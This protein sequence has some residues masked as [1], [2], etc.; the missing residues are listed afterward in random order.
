MNR[1]VA[2]LALVFG[3]AGAISIGCGSDDDAASP[4]AGGAGGTAGSGGRAGAA[5]HAGSSG[6]AGARNDGGSAGEDGVAGSGAGAEQGGAGGD[7]GDAAG[8]GPGGEGGESGAGGAGHVFTQQ[9]LDR[10]KLI[11][12][13]MALGGGCHSVGATST[14]PAGPELGGNPAFFSSLGA[15][16]LT[17][18]PSG[19]G[20]FSDAEVI[21]SFRNGI[22]L[23]K[24]SNDQDRHLH[25]I[26]P[27]W[28]FHNMS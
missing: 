13:S 5:G 27:Y 6:N 3:L 18:D 21:N 9:Q 16:N 22:A 2:H 17:N 4:N 20:E 26:M 19:I 15:P 10:G 25:A 28:L 23:R 14:A 24:G 11:V 8:S 7:H 12:R 1:R